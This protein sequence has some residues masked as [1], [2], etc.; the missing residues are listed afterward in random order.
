[1]QVQSIDLLTQPQQTTGRSPTADSVIGAPPDSFGEVLARAQPHSDEADDV[2]ATLGPVAPRIEAAAKG[3]G[4]QDDSAD[5]PDCATP[6][7]SLA[8]PPSAATIP[9]SPN[10]TTRQ[11]ANAQPP[12]GTGAAVI[13]EEAITTD[14]LA[15]NGQRAP[16]AVTLIQATSPVQVALANAIGLTATSIGNAPATAETEGSVQVAG[17]KTQNAAPQANGKIQPASTAARRGAA[18]PGIQHT[19]AG[20]GADMARSKT[21][22]PE[23]PA[24]TAST[25][26]IGAAADGTLA[27]AGGTAPTDGALAPGFA[28]ERADAATRIGAQLAA[29]RTPPPPPALAG[30]QVSVHIQ[31]AVRSGADRIHI[32]LHPAELGRVE[33]KLDIGHD[34]AVTAI[35]TTEKP[36]AAEL[37]SRDARIL[38]RA[39][40]DAGLRADTGSLSFRHS[41][42][43]AHADSQRNPASMTQLPN[44]GG[45]SAATD[46]STPTATVARTRHDGFVDLDA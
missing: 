18:D 42:D 23:M 44:T 31:N 16:L 12:G 46:M 41:G 15:A 39:L 21:A 2:A 40:E 19:M 33:V 24:S 27:L 43:N 7:A 3:S 20:T 1:M 37:L 30:E 17:S 9:V 6:V 4:R 38:Q 26:M 25:Q 34:R 14:S 10:S 36:E 11:V 22:T 35:V 5:A 28:G 29:A 13:S 45:T 32:R 8:A